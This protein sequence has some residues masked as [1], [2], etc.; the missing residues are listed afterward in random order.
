MNNNFENIGNIGII[1][2]Y[3]SNG[4]LHEEYFQNNKKIEGSYK[5]YFQQDIMDM[6][7]ILLEGKYIGGIKY[8]LFTHYYF[9]GQISEEKNYNND[10]LNGEYKCYFEDGAIEC[11]TFYIN[12]KKN[13]VYK[14]DDGTYT[15]ISNLIDD[16]N[17][18][19]EIIYYNANGYITNEH[20]YIYG[21]KN[22][23]N[24]TYYY[25]TGSLFS[26]EYFIDDK[27]ISIRKM[28]DGICLSLY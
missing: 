11:E 14:S 2:T 16:K 12:N 5:S 9:H 15:T 23:I 18:G 6:P 13:G 26:E 21:K 1:R 27:Q 19:T 3:Y 22:G 20:N 24:K 10:I 25:K 4:K 8:G 17:H 7:H 28:Y